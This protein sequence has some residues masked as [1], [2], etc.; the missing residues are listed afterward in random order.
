MYTNIQII[1]LD[2]QYNYAVFTTTDTLDFFQ[3]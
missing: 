1:I 2:G 3:A